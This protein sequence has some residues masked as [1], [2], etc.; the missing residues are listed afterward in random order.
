MKYG[1]LRLLPL[2]LLA[3]AVSAC[4]GESD[5][6]E[7]EATTAATP[8]YDIELETPAEAAAYYAA[9]DVYLLSNFGSGGPTTID[10]DG[11]ISR[12][13]AE[14]GEVVELEWISGDLSA[15]KGMTV[16]GDTLY[17]ADKDAVHTYD[18]ANG[19]APLRKIALDTSQVTFPNDVCA[20]ADGVVYLTDS[21]LN[22][23]FSPSGTDAVYR[24]EGDSLVQVASG[25]DALHGPNGCWVD[26]EGLLVV[27][28]GANEVLRIGGDGSVTTAATLPSGGLDGIV[29]SDG[30]VYV[31]S[32]EA[33]S[34]YR[35]DVATG[36]S[37]VVSPDTPSPAALGIDTMRDRLVV[38]LLDLQTGPPFRVAVLQLGA[39]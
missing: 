32:W 12:V 5:V 27:T 11:F 3:F 29:A 26:D 22:S 2:V 35:L 36:E 34:V 30:T 8:P 21:G 9:D 13:D 37:T 17:V 38:P 14:T 1:A 16:V 23:D 33:G 24:L 19:G 18:L 20:G 7:E 25:A 39:E 28:F 31:T 10:E 6:P 15:P 4:E